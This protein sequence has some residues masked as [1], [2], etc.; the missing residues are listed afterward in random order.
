MNLLPVKQDIFSQKE[1]HGK[2]GVYGP[3][4]KALFVTSDQ[5]FILL[6]AQTFVSTRA[7]FASMLF[8]QCTKPNH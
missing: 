4:L 3:A 2:Q 7:L 6:Y 1:N 5:R 8:N